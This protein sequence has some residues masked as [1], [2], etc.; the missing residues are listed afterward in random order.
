MFRA[1]TLSPRQL[2]AGLVIFQVVIWTLVPMLFHTSLP[3]DV[4][5]EGLAWGHEWQLG[6]YKHPPLPSWLVEAS[7]QLAGDMGPLL[8]GQLSMA[9][10]FIAIYFLGR[11]LIGSRDAVVGVICL[12]GVYYYSLPTVEFN[13]NV[14]QMPVWAAMILFY[15]KALRSGQ[16]IWWILLGLTGGIGLLSKYTVLLLMAL[17]FIYSLS[18]PAYRKHYSTMGP[19]LAVG[20]VLLVAAPHIYWLLEND[21]PSLS[22]L[23]QRSG[24]VGTLLMRPLKSL[25]FLSAQLAAVLP[26]LILL[27]SGGLLKKATGSIPLQKPDIS[28]ADR[29]YLLVFGL[30]PVLIA[31]IIPLV[32]GTELRS[33]WGM[34]MLSLVGLM[35]VVLLGT[36]W[37]TGR[38]GRFL[39]AGMLLF[40]FLASM[41]G[42]KGIVSARYAERPTRTVWPD[43]EI[44]SRLERNWVSVTGCRLKIVTA[45]GWLG[46]LVAMRSPSRPSVFLEGDYKKAPWISKEALKENGSLVVWITGGEG[47]V[48]EVYRLLPGFSYRGI[49]M[50]DWPGGNKNARPITLG[51]GVVPGACTDRAPG[52]VLQ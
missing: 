10:S 16:A 32:S 49:E 1:D 28:E 50:F 11:E 35:A 30:G 42:L 5:R 46:G 41:Y 23:N 43:T 21:F 9:I 6:Y 27:W 44:A 14:A 38:I 36:P 4:V 39:L 34:P 25:E 22:Y 18:R 33:M 52:A 29:E 7:F 15:Y 13:H 31:C 8:L 48:P 51:W 37:E 40:V 26:M 19:Y 17:M 24:R 2:L 45:D 12:V 3:L 47:E 20:I